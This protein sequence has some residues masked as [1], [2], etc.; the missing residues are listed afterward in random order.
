MRLRGSATSRP[1]NRPIPAPTTTRLPT[2]PHHL[3]HDSHD[4][5]R[6]TDKLPT[7]LTTRP[8]PHPSRG[9]AGAT[10][11]RSGAGGAYVALTGFSSQCEPLR[12]QPAGRHAPTAPT[13]G[14]TALGGTG[15]SGGHDAPVT[16]GAA[17][18]APTDGASMAGERSRGGGGNGWGTRQMRQSNSLARSWP[19]AGS[20]SVHVTVLASSG[21]RLP[22]PWLSAYSS[23]QSTP[24]TST[25]S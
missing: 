1:S 21:R 24:P 19:T 8:P 18:P 11:G 20:A 22:R 5:T 23:G 3:D 6:A 25:V 16:V 7:N 15:A 4:V 2:A 14:L 13:A 9:P 12:G 17:G 10:A